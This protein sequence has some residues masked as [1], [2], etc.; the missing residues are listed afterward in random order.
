M[1]TIKTQPASAKALAS[2]HCSTGMPSEVQPSKPGPMSFRSEYPAAARAVE[3]LAERPP[4]L[5][6]MTRGADVSG[7]AVLTC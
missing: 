4:A 6:A 2:L 3:A 1:G 5:H 7:K